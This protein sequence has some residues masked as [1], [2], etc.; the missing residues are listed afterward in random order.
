MPELRIQPLLPSDQEAVW[1]LLHIALWDPPPAPLR[2]RDVLNS[3]EVRIYAEDW[4]RREGDIGV[5][6]RLDGVAEIVGACWLRLVTGGVGL[7]YIDDITP[8]LGIALLPAHQR[9]GYGKKL[10]LAALAEAGRRY[11]QVALSVHPDNP[12]AGLYQRCGFKQVDVRRNYLI[13]VRDMTTDRA[14]A[15]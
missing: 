2:P 8:Q 14:A 12:A 11:R 5:C 13:M 3:P 4:G 6:G 9:R 15:G 7:S 1:D 10:L